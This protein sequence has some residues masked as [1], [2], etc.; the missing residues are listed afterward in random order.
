VWAG[1]E[2]VVGRRGGIKPRSGDFCLAGDLRIL[3]D[4]VGGFRGALDGRGLHG[5]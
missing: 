1:F 5:D 4:A 3:L 2:V